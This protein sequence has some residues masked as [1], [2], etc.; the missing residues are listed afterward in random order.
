MRTLVLGLGNPILTDDGVG[1][2]VANAVKSLLPDSE[3]IDFA[4]VS[5][6]GLAVMEALIGY[7]RVIIIDAL[8]YPT[9]DS[10]VMVKMKLEDL[11]KISAIQHN[12]SPHDTNLITA[13]EAGKKLG[14]PLPEDITIYAVKVENIT[15]FGE[16]PSPRVAKAIPQIA[17]AILADLSSKAK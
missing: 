1:I 15:D 10:G 7:D 13:I 8:T 16:N 3:A 2:H 11:R 17:A 6:G 9:H 12:A 5:I 14:Y 4:E